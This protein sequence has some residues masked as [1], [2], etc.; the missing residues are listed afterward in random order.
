MAKKLSF[1]DEWATIHEE[2]VLRMTC[3]DADWLIGTSR[4]ILCLDWL[5][6]CDVVKWRYPED[7]NTNTTHDNDHA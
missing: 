6:L 4:C 3:P 5:S 7:L 1:H 2:I